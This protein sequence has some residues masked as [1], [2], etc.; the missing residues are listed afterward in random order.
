MNLLHHKRQDVITALKKQLH[1]KQHPTRPLS[2]QPTGWLALDQALGGGLLRGALNEILVDEEA[3]GVLEAL[4]PALR[5]TPEISGQRPGFWAWVHPRRLPYPPALAQWHL[6]LE[7]WL[8]VHPRHQEEQLWAMETIMQS[9][10]CETLVSFLEP[11]SQRHLDHRWRRLQWA[12]Q[13]SHTL[14][15]ILRSARRV[16]NASPAPLRLLARALPDRERSR[17]LS[18]EVLKCRGQAPGASLVLEWSHD[19]LD[20]PPLSHS[21]SGRSHTGPGACSPQAIRS[22]RA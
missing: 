4:L 9:G 2:H 8:V 11:Q 12:A 13:K 15:L 19:A 21:C 1:Q 3:C 6:P 18:I 10:L 22:L 17:R 14:V 20:Q 5:R 16:L 7:R